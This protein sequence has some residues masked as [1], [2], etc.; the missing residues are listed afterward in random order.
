M[1]NLL[2]LENLSVRF[3]NSSGYVNAVKDVSFAIQK[4]EIFGL[5]GESGCGKSVTAKTILALHDKKSTVVKGSIR[6]EDQEL[7]GIS[8]EGA[9]SV[10]GSRAAMIFQD[11]MTSLDPLMRVGEQISEVLVH[12]K[13][14]RKAEAKEEAVRL[15]EK[16]GIT[17]PEKRYA[18][19]PH[20]FSGGMLQRIMIAIALSCRPQLLI[21]DEPTTALDV[22]IQAQIMKLMKT[23]KEETGMAILIITHDLG[24]VAEFCDTVGVMYAGQIV[25]KADLQKI[26]KEPCHPYN[27]GLMQAIPRLGEYREFLN[28]IEGM[29]PLLSQEFQGCAF[30]PRCPHRVERCDTEP[31]E[32]LEI[33]P[34]HLARCHRSQELLGQV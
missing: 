27:I 6:L 25:E 20:E 16:V 5:V 18:Q 13:K 28:V 30:A 14:L 3:K 1:E 26:F 24:V 34:G 21:A 8:G 9:N 22:T 4:G 33:T 10:R 23:M 17:S 11:P 32:L 15:M 7:I 2:T 31:P 12:H 19:Y 29:P